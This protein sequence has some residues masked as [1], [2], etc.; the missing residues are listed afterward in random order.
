VSQL[1][2][3]PPKA[4]IRQCDLL[5][6][7][8]P[9]SDWPPQTFHVGTTFNPATDGSTLRVESFVPPQGSRHLRM[10]TPPLLENRFCYVPPAKLH[11]PGE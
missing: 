3:I 1:F 8:V 10:R 4:D 2:P 5:V 7:F 9:N 11:C 6:R